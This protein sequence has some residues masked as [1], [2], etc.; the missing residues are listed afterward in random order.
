LSILAYAPDFNR[1]DPEAIARILVLVPYCQEPPVD[2]GSLRQTSRQA[3]VMWSKVVTAAG[4]LEAM[5]RHR[6]HTIVF[7]SSCATS[8]LRRLR[9]ERG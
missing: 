5:L 4:V 2:T 9:F 3:K 8:A 6:A 7:S 1:G